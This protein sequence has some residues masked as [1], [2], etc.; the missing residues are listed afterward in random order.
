MK[1][2]TI[3]VVLR[4]TCIVH[5]CFDFFTAFSRDRKLL[6]VPVLWLSFLSV[7]EI[8]KTKHISDIIS[9]M[10]HIKRVT[11]PMFRLQPLLRGGYYDHFRRHSSRWSFWYQMKAPIFLNTPMKCYVQEMFLVKVIS[12]NVPKVRLQQSWLHASQWTY[13]IWTFTSKIRTT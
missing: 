3:P 10:C 13:L 5:T 1:L 7:A 4:N 11:L 9:C 8:N 6:P 12:E 2:H